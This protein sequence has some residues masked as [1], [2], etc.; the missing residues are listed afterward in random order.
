VTASLRDELLRNLES[1]SGAVSPDCEDDTALITSGR[2]DSMALYN[3]SLWIEEKTGRPFDPALVNIVAEWDTIGRVIAFVERAQSGA[4]APAQSAAVL[5][6]VLRRAVEGGYTIER[7]AP[8]FKDAVIGL[9]SRLWSSDA[10]LNRRFFEWR[11]E[12]N[13]FAADPLIYVA[14]KDGAVV[15]TRA[16]CGSLWEHGAGQCTWYF[17]DD[18]V[19]L[20]EHESHGVFAAFTDVMKDDLLSRGA[21]IFLSLSALRVTRLQSLAGGARNVGALHPVAYQTA[22]TRARQSARDFTARLPLAWRL[23]SHMDTHGAARRAFDR[24]D[25]FSGAGPL[26]SGPVRARD[27]SALVARLPHDGRFRMVRDERFFEW[28]YASPLHEYR[29]LYL[30]DDSGLAGYLVLERNV[31]DLAN[32]TRVNIADWEGRTPET[33]EKLLV[34]ALERA[35][36]EELVCW[37][38][39][40][41]AA[42]IACL[43]KAGFRAI[44]HQQ[45]ARGLPSILVWPLQGDA[46]YVG[47][48][49]LLDLANWDLRMTY[50]SMA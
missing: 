24:F 33:L 47:G 23:S 38:G 49:S 21:S 40:L 7:Y 11:Y 48:R 2:L 50:T 43:E 8:G 32:S 16:L 20:P 15:A 10:A 28:R 27:L 39:T 29:F 17:A 41:G 25:A 9:Q 1:W 6:P 13:P 18:L 5:A 19:V 31:S 4:A 12:R 34:G 46:P 30:D 26:T 42:R 45:T 14:V 36:P 44:D 37:S 35:R 3:L 22:A